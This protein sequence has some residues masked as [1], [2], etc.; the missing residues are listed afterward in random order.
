MTRLKSISLHN[1]IAKL[2]AAADT[3]R[4]RA[5]MMVVRFIVSYR[6]IPAPSFQRKP[7]INLRYR[8]YNLLLY[9]NMHCYSR[10]I[11]LPVNL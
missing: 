1:N 8:F 2:F 3:R 6:D 5:L 9:V 4:L 7:S 11:C 10:V